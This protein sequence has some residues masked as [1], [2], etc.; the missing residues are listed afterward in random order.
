MP[1]KGKEVWCRNVDCVSLCSGLER[2]MSS[3]DFCTRHFTTQ[4][5]IIWAKEVRGG[6]KYLTVLEK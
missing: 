2:Y 5:C 3:W 1:G 6:K 4:V